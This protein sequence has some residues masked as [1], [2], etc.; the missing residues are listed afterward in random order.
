MCGLLLLVG[1][2]AW[3]KAHPTEL[4]YGLRVTCWMKPTVAVMVGAGPCACPDNCMY[5]YPERIGQPQGVAPTRPPIGQLRQGGVVH[6]QTWTEGA[7]SVGV[8][9]EGRG[10]IG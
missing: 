5:T 9:I 3:A 4:S 10:G 1:G 8:R 2:S 6:Y 7:W